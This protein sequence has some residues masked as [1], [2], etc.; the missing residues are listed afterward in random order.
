MGKGI[1]IVT[2]SILSLLALGLVVG[3]PYLVT[4]AVQQSTERVLAPITEVNQQLRTQVAQLL[5]P[6]PTIIPDPVTIL[7]EIRSLARLETIQYTVEKVITAELGHK[8]LRFLFGER[9]LFV[10]HGSVIAGVDLSRM[11]IEDLSME[12]GTLY[13]SLPEPEVF[14]A[15][16]DNQ[17]SYVYDRDTGLLK[18]ADLNLETQARMAAEE[19]ILNAALE[20]GILEKARLNAEQYLERLFNRLGYQRVIF[21]E[22]K[23]KP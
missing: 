17:R 15:T 7:N 9:L 23:P 2:I 10:A 8:D 4:N 12:G 22:A 1:Y 19:E 14:I 5:N 18:R 11:T 21:R 6:T 3:I 16:L 13:V 20:D